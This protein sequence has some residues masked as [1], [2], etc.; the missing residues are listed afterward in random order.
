VVVGGSVLQVAS[1][2]GI[3]TLII[4]ALSCIHLIIF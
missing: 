3:N 2:D 1:S 4:I